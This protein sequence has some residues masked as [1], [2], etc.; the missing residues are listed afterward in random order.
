ML[1]N[2]RQH[3]AA[4]PGQSRMRLPPQ[5]DAAKVDIPAVPQVRKPCDLAH[6]C[7]YPWRAGGCEE[8][9]Q[10]RWSHSGFLIYYDYSVLSE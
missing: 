4:W 9:E 5:K 2:K 1:S 3:S 7:R 8:A 10:V 6:A